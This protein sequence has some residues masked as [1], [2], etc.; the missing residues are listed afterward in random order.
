MHIT[1]SSDECETFWYYICN[2]YLANSLAAAA[3][4]AATV[5]EPHL[6]RFLTFHV[7]NLIR[8]SNA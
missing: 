7:L 6:Y 4:T 5:S 1:L 2:L 8:F 3:V